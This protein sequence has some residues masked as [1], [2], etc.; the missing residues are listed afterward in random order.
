MNGCC[1]REGGDGSGPW[2]RHGEARRRRGAGPVPTPGSP[3]RNGTSAGH[4]AQE[5][6][7][8]QTRINKFKTWKNIFFLKTM[9]Y[10]RISLLPIWSFFLFG[11]RLDPDWFFSRAG[12][13]EEEKN[14][15]LTTGSKYKKFVHF[16]TRLKLI[17]ILTMDF[18]EAVYYKVNIWWSIPLMN[19]VRYRSRRRWGSW[20]TG[21]CRRPRR[22]W[23]PRSS[24]R[25][26][27][28]T[29]YS[30]IEERLCSCL[31]DMFCP[32]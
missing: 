3:T 30:C 31:C 8:V 32:F 16:L 12:S 14:R 18:G 13:G 7:F 2:R 26:D 15:I 1:W 6:S 19:T 28:L 25:R 29:R 20:R 5:I 11:L 21:R 22:S 23:R 4:I 9:V 17:H 24:R 27:S 10:K